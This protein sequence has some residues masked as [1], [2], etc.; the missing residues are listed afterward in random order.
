MIKAAKAII[1]ELDGRAITLFL[2]DKDEVKENLKKLPGIG[3]NSAELLLLYA[4]EFPHFPKDPLALRALERIRG[5][6]L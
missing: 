6:K 2:G 4:A 3:E 5:K 1:E